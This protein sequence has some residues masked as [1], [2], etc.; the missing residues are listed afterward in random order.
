MTDCVLRKCIEDSSDQEATG[1]F[2]LMIKTMAIRRLINFASSHGE[3]AAVE[4]LEYMTARSVPSVDYDFCHR[5]VIVLLA[6]VC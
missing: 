1:H 6:M 5:S 4:V 2:P 3:I